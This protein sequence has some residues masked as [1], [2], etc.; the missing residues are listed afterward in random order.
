MDEEKKDM[1]LSEQGETSQGEASQGKTSQKETAQPEVATQPETQA[2]TQ[3]E[4]ADMEPQEDKQIEETKET[5]ESATPK[6]EENTQEATNTQ[7][8]KKGGAVA[9]VLVGLVAFVAVLAF[10]WYSMGGKGGESYADTGVAYA[11]ENNLY[12][13]DL[14][15]EPALVAEG[16]S[17]GGQYNSYYSAWG[18]LF[19][20]DGSALYYSTNVTAENT[21]DLYYRDMNNSGADVL[22]AEGAA[23]YMLTENGDHIIYTKPKA[24]DEYRAELYLFDGQ[25][26][27]LIDDSVFAD[28]STYAISGD[29]SF[30]MYCKLEDEN[31]TALALYAKEAKADAEA[32][33]LEPSVAIAMMSAQSNKIYYAGLMQTEDESAAA[34][35]AAYEYSLGK[36]PVKIL[37]SVT[38][39]EV[40]PNG[41]DV[42][43]MS[44][45]T[46]NVPYSTFIEDDL[47]E[48]DAA[49]TEADGEAY[50]EKQAR[51]E[52]RA[53]MAAG[54]G[55]EPVL[56]NV[57]IYNNDKLTQVAENAIATVAVDNDRPFAVCYVS[58]EVQKIPISV[59]DSL[60]TAEY[61]YYYGLYYATPNAVLVNASGGNWQLEGTSVAADEIVLSQD[62][63]KVMY[64]DT[65]LTTGAKVLKVAKVGGEVLFEMQNVETARFLGNSDAVGYYK[66]YE[67]GVGTLGIWDN[68]N[69]TEIQ[70]VAGVHF[71]PDQAAVYYLTDMDETTGNGTL[72]VWKDGAEQQI[73]T[74][75]SN[76]QY[77]YN[78]KMAYM[79]QYDFTT[80]IGDLYYYDGEN[81]KQLDSGVTAIYA[82]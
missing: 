32:I 67:N 73:D 2:E 78:G 51:D 69:E 23:D 53:A 80:G 81:T 75:V 68:G 74:E 61:S 38:Y 8:Q 52:I 45:G 15:N 13:Y 63:T 70:Q 47:A 58:A 33:L 10:C 12:L 72:F 40:M 5:E 43:L 59:L 22:V 31:S 62:G 28:G 6:A 55:I 35:Y 16:I 7:P 20:E 54:E 26:S 21:F 36:E 27:Y 76:T 17:S 39:L 24:D 46:E 44:K 79:K 9:G 30:V 42:L 49:L 50:T 29:G 1:T 11:K 19:S 71:A 60:E 4:Q 25:E 64:Y 82:F 14:E 37:D 34:E 18:T 41:K 3:T 57:F 65:D 77:K 66:D 48:S 56:Q